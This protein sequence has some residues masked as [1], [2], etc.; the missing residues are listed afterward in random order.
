[1]I[2]DGN[3]PPPEPSPAAKPRPAELARQNRIL[4]ETVERLLHENEE[5]TRRTAELQSANVDSRNSRRATL[6][7]LEDA[8]ASRQLAEYLNMQLQLENAE[9]RRAETTLR[10][11]EQRARALMANLP[12]GAVFIL[13]RE[14]RYLLADGEAL[15]TI[16]LKPADLVGR[17]IQET[18]SLWQPSGFE[19]HYLAALAGDAF[20]F[21]HEC[22]GRCFLSRGTPLRDDSGRIEGIMA[23][24]FDIT[25][26]RQTEEAL[27]ESKRNLEE[28][29]DAAQAAH[30]AKDQF[31]A[32]LSHELRTPL[33]PILITASLCADDPT[34]PERA[35]AQFAMVRNNVKLEAHL[36]D[37][38]LD[39]TQI[40]RG[41]TRLEKHAVDLHAVIRDALQTVGPE[42][43]VKGITPELRLGARRTQVVADPVRLQQIF[44]NLLRNAA[45][46]T[47][48]QGRVT[49][50]SDNLARGR[51]TV[52]IADTGIGLTKIEMARAFQPFTQGD[53]ATGGT[54]SPFGGLGL[55]LAISQRLI[56]LHGG[57]IKAT[58]AG[59]GKGATF[60]VELPV[61]TQRLAPAT[62]RPART[63]PRGRPAERLPRLLVVEDHAATRAAL[64]GL[65]TGR[66]HEVTVAGSVAEALEKAAGTSFDLVLSDLGLPDGSGH[67]LMRQLRTI[68]PG[69]VGIALSGFG[70]E[71]DVRQA[72]AAGFFAHLTKPVSIEQLDAV[73]WEIDQ[74]RTR[75]G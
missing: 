73:L 2:T 1:M 25:A 57:Q 16:G 34:L 18:F 28:A 30:Q 9:R 61:S 72:R 51:I 53:H 60:T 59:R 32:T 23:V 38:L 58:S 48:L 15:H 49:I 66:G 36:I 39:Q 7:V 71:T 33:T 55:G 68:Q 43:T 50:R 52:G 8:L 31:I 42:F 5:L 27:R 22:H 35:R 63:I 41:K 46:F 65:F 75:V 64:G 56:G 24:A 70:M 20:M 62:R 44:W 12:G 54:T 10:M 6:N 17:T 29:L 3:N 4:R 37:D 74:S 47:P 21:E 13:D 69:L 26:R 14:L 19:S 40:I 45:K 11:S 67:D